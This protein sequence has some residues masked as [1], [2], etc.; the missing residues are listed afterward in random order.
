M[1]KEFI[2]RKLSA[3]I[4]PVMVGGYRASDGRKLKQVRIGSS[5]TIIRPEQLSLNDNT[6]I[7]QYNFLDASNGLQIGE[8]CQITSYVSLL[9]HSSH[10]SIRL[11]GR[12]Y[13]NVPESEK[14][15][16]RRGPVHI[17]EYTFIGPHVVVMPGTKIGKGCIVSAFSYLDGEYPDYAIISGQPAKV[18]GDT[19]NLD[20]VFLKENPELLA[21]YKE[22]S[23]DI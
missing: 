4:R 7:G 15:G 11:Y 10:I 8:G 22:W 6:Y 23:N 9:T 20:A 13:V 2:I 16:Y 12:D 17:G 19:R 5:T 3:W 21:G 1:L 18:S 14:I